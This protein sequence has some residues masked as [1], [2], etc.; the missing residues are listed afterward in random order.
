MVLMLVL[1]MP[2]E[3][4]ARYASIVVDASSGRIVHGRHIDTRLY[5]ASMT[6][7][8]TLY[9]LFEALDSGRLDM[10]SRLSVSR[11]AAGQT[12]SKLGLKAGSTI[13]VRDAIR[14]LVVK[15][16]ND[17]A[18]VVAEALGST[19][20]GFARLMTDKARSLGMRDTTFMN[21][22][23]L[24]NRGQKSTARDMAILSMALMKH[25]PHHYHY[26]SST[27]FR[28]NGR[29][30]TGHNRLLTRYDGADG[31]KTGYISASGFNIAVS[32]ARNGRRLI[33]VVFGGR[34]A[35]SRDDHM[36]ELLD[37]GF[38]IVSQAGY[39]PHAG[40]RIGV[41]AAPALVVAAAPIP[42]ALPPGKAAPPVGPQ[43]ASV[44]AGP[45]EDPAP[46]QAGLT[47][48]DLTALI[49]G[50]VAMTKPDP[51]GADGPTVAATAPA[52]V[53]VPAPR[54]APD[55]A[56]APTPAEPGTWG[57]Q[58]GAFSSLATAEAAARDAARLLSARL[59]TVKVRVIPH[60]IS[61]G[62]VYRARLLGMGTEAQA[63]DA[64]RDLRARQ[65]S[66]L[67]VVPTGWT[68]A[69]R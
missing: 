66:C 33:G 42:P 14:A 26:F 10:D 36:V 35:R 4:A 31:L 3:A 47:P 39:T 45:I 65:R 55:G 58:V 49:A 64:C 30:Y 32:A 13:A 37:K 15:S 19:E 17:V 9:L 2:G 20:V 59:E 27:S 48:P 25:F 60:T 1:I 28:F 43:V 6:K 62:K 53:P 40:N 11:R 12:P 63:R 34:T 50:V 46:V 38:R 69:A 51:A 41:P 5:P 22:S 57:I 54:P 21:A 23:G 18:T 29:T 67:V 61:D 24:P 16:A 8:M 52:G 44:T 68:I 56:A 7:M